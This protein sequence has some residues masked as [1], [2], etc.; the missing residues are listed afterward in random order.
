MLIVATVKTNPFS[1]VKAFNVWLNVCDPIFEQ[2]TSIIDMLHTASLVI[3][4]IE[5][6]SSLRRGIPASHS[7]YGIPASV[8]SA[9][10]A[11][12][13]SLQKLID[14]LPKEKQMDAIRIFSRQMIQLHRGQGLE[15]YWRENY[16]CPSEEEYVQVITLKTS[17]LFGMAIELLQL[18]SDFKGDLSNLVYLI[19]KIYQIRNDYLAFVVNDE[20]KV[21]AEDLTEGKF[22]LPIIHAIH[23]DNN[24]NSTLISKQK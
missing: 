15:I 13:L 8:N 18:F 17:G 10:Y 19:G 7:V 16:Q 20:K 22:T 24:N 4:D 21:F 23:F 11:Y 9:N 3:D 2:I 14:C 1:S 12:F 6:F 5:D